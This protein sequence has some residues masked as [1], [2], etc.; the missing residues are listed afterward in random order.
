KNIS[1][2][3]NTYKNKVLPPHPISNPGLDAIL[4]VLNPEKRN[5]YFIFM[6]MKEKFIARK[7]MKSTK[8]ILKNI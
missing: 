6:I 5:A 3:F 2:P 4:A 8:L 7:L 1:S